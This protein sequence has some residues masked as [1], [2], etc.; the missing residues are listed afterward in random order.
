M[1]TLPSTGRRNDIRNRYRQRDT[2]IQRIPAAC[3][4]LPNRVLPRTTLLPDKVA[5]NRR[6]PIPGYDH[7]S[8]SSVHGICPPSSRVPL[9]QRRMKGLRWLLLAAM[10]C[11]LGLVASQALAILGRYI[12]DVPQSAVDDV[13][14]SCASSGGAPSIIVENSDAH[15]HGDSPDAALNELFPAPIGPG[16]RSIGVRG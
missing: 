5:G 9:T 10:L 1:S 4:P 13:R 15:E 2:E 12:P 3:R 7:H 14:K 6:G 11:S 8:H 16:V